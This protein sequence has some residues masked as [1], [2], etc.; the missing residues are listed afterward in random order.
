MTGTPFKHLRCDLRVQVISCTSY[1]CHCAPDSHHFQQRLQSH[2]RLPVDLS[3]NIYIL[4]L[5]HHFWRLSLLLLVASLS[6]YSLYRFRK[7]VRSKNTTKLRNLISGT[8]KWIYVPTVLN[9]VSSVALG[10]F[11]I[12]WWVFRLQRLIPSTSKHVDD[13]SW[14]G[15]KFALA[16]GFIILTG[17]AWYCKLFGP[18]PSRPNH[19][20]LL[21]KNASPPQTWA[22]L[23]TASSQHETS[24]KLNAEKDSEKQQSDDTD[25]LKAYAS[26]IR[27]TAFGSQIPPLLLLNALWIAL[28]FVSSLSSD[29]TWLREIYTHQIN[30][31]PCLLLWIWFAV[32]MTLCG[33]DKLRDLVAACE[34]EGFLD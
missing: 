15:L 29:S 30:Y 16:T 24:G 25:A 23:K 14:H 22:A 32:T 10:V 3:K 6:A 1:S 21:S 13:P 19:P 5:Q 26:T 12:H 28:F 20:H 17:M 11:W 7:A 31:A 18:F 33:L 27:Q 2:Q 9:L 4:W 34:Q 8:D